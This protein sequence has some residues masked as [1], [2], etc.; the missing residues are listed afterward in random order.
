M[1]SLDDPLISIRLVPPENWADALELLFRDL[2]EGVR[3]RQ[4]EA[5][6]EQFRA[7][8]AT[9]SGLLEARS[10]E[11]RV[12]SILVQLQPGRVPSLWPLQVASEVECRSKLVGNG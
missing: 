3:Q 10:S 1:P 8:P 7:E 9:A 11:K 6:V 4:L 12:G 2:P 5:T